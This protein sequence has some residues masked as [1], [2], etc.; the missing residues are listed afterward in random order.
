VGR[1]AAITYSPAKVRRML[2]AG[3]AE[4]VRRERQGDFKPFT[5]DRPYHVEFKLRKSFPDSIVQGVAALSEF[6]LEK[7]GE[8][9]FRL[10]TDS[11]KEMGWL[12]DAIEETVLR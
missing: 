3:A 12:L 2:Q 9:N 1:S 10:T 11:A 8:R 6:K 4:A 5:L 7:T